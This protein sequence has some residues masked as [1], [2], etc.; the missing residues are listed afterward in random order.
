MR[1]P[2][3]DKLLGEAVDRGDVPGIAVVVTDADKITYEG[4]AGRR[5]S[6]RPDPMTPDTVGWI[7]SMTK[8][9]TSVAALQQVERGRLTLDGQIAEVLPDLAEPQVLEGFDADG[10]PRLRP[11]RR[12]IT[13]R[14][15]LTH[16]A[17]FGYDIWSADLGRYMEKRGVPGIISC[18]NKAL[19]TPLT[20]DPGERWQYGINIDWAGKAVE[21]V[22]GKGLDRYLEDEILGPLGM[23]DTAFRLGTDQRARLSAMHARKP[24]GGFETV[25]FEVP[26][27]PEFCMGG[28]GLYGTARD[29]AAFI[30]MVL[31]DGRADGAQIL[32]PETVALMN[33]NQIGVI[34]IGP[35]RTAMPALSN[36]VEFIAGIGAKWGLAYLVTP[37]AGPAGRSPGSLAWGGLANSYYWIDP[38]KKLGGVVLTQLLPFGDPAILRLCGDFERE[39]YRT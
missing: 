11:A 12:P 14:H 1:G 3:I 29:Y 31:N 24:E 22:S 6:D 27:V 25:P 10:E 32:K 8:A 9:V 28:G 20:F 34:E 39:V 26:Q 23:R 15:L 17:G 36:D 37:E 21:A 5:S 30:R 13:L 4:A 18:E 7:A 19:T 33:G 35:M 38:A 2:A 16:T